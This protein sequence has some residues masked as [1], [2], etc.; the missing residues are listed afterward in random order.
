MVLSPEPGPLV[1]PGRFNGPPAGANGGYA[2]GLL[3]GAAAGHLDGPPQVALHL[4]VPL[5]TPLEYE[6]AGRRGHAYAR[7]DLVATVST[8]RRA[9]PPVEPVP[10]EAAATAHEGFAGRSGHPFPTCFVCGTDRPGDGLGLT[11]GPAGPPGTVACVWTPSAALAAPGGR[12]PAEIV[13][14][15]LDCPGGWTGDLVAEP[16]VLASMSARIEA[17]PR[18]GRRHVIVGRRVG[19]AGRTAT[20]ATALYDA[21]GVLLAGALANWVTVAG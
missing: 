2:C 17:L 12:V 20:T 8:A 11:P 13:W 10:A 14:G 1:V 19:V 9:V 6:K 3:A 18:A 15:A 7:G 5:D 16:R 21:E 4:P